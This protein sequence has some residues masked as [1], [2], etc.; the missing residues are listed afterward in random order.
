MVRRGYLLPN[1]QLKQMNMSKE[2][3]KQGTH[4][5]TLKPQLSSTDTKGKTK[6]HGHK[7]LI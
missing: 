7:N 5:R 2:I 1:F 3:G 6:I 4:N